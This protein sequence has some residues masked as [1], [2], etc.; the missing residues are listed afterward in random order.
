MWEC[1][2]LANKRREL[3]VELAEADPDDLTPAIRK[4]GR[5]RD[6]RGPRKNLLGGQR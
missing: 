2:K 3:D 5:K 1:E 6:E 4:G